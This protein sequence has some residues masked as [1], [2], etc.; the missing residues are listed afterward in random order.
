MNAATKFAGF[1]LGLAAIFA[2]ALGAGA[3][4]GPEP[5]RPHSHEAETPGAA[6][7]ATLSGLTNTESGY[8]L[9]LEDTQ[10]TSA[11]DAPL[12]FRIQDHTGTPVTRYTTT[13]DKDL[14]LIVV[15]RDMAAFQHVHPVLDN[16][17]T[18]T[19]PL[20][21]T[22]AGDYRVYADFVTEDGHSHILGADLRVAGNYAPRPLPALTTVTSVDGYQV[23]LEGTAVPG[24][25]AQ[26]TL[27]VS[28][29]GRPVTDLEPY[30]GAYGHLVALRAADL[31]YLH[32]HPKGHPG[33]GVTAP[34]PTI[35]FAL[36]APTAGDYRLFLDFQHRGEVHTAEFTLPVAPGEATEAGARSPAG[37]GH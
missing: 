13:H 10:T 16:T 8:T 28:R 4:I 3:A 19:V 20:D 9:V 33:D 24:Q 36:T 17:G 31:G 1:A 12:R 5:D 25:T 18:W 29:D 2:I 22:Q 27:T 21:L 30:L 14:H 15:R 26:V 7:H 35:T 34:G 6:D 37:H 32:V 23:A 11:P